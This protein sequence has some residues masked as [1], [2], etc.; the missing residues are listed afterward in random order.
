[1]RGIGLAIAIATMGALGNALFVYG[2]RRAQVSDAPF[3]F[4]TLYLVVATVCCLLVVPLL[5]KTN[6]MALVSQNFMWACWTGL[7]LAVTLVAFYFLF[8]YFGATFYALY[9]VIAILTT[10]LLVGQILLREPINLF[11]VGAILLA[12]GSVLLFTLGR[13]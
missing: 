11:H 1:M 12:V 5:P 10:T 8:T 9:S 7:G 6:V 4:V 2:Q 3:V 13:T